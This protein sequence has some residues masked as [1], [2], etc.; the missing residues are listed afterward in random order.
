VVPEDGFNMAMDVG[1]ML[2][3]EPQTSPEKEPSKVG[4][5][6]YQTCPLWTKIQ[7][8]SL[9]VLVQFGFN[10]DRQRAVDISPQHYPVFQFGL[11]FPCCIIHP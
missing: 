9:L 5:S 7:A 2:P 11:T 8:A 6:C 10:T 1:D 3:E 4:V